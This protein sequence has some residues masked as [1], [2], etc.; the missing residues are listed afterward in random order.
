MISKRLVPFNPQP[1]YSSRY[2][3]SVY[4]RCALF[5][6]FKL[7]TW[8]PPNCTPE[9]EAR[10]NFI[11]PIGPENPPITDR[12]RNAIEDGPSQRE[13]PLP[14]TDANPINMERTVRICNCSSFCNK[15]LRALHE[16]PIKIVPCGT[17]YLIKRLAP[18][19]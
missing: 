4:I 13:E 18:I 5:C 1:A 12:R 15:L 11:G 10:D 7:S 19:T 2:L 17:E 3:H 8:Q 9:I 14:L 16:F 6:I